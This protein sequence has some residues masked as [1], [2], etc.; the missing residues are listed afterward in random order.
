MHDDLR[1]MIPAS[2]GFAKTDDETVDIGSTNEATN[3]SK[4][5]QE[6]EIE[7]VGMDESSIGTGRVRY[8][9]GLIIS[10]AYCRVQACV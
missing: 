6:F 9:I 5:A 4:I 3:V 8:K 1:K 2:N 10:I 7:Y